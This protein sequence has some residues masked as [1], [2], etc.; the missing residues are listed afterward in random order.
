MLPGNVVGENVLRDF[1]LIAVFEVDCREI[2]IEPGI[3][4]VSLLRAI[5]ARDR[6][7]GDYRASSVTRRGGLADPSAFIVPDRSDSR[8]RAGAQETSVCAVIQDLSACSSRILSY[9]SHM[10]LFVAGK[11]GP[12]VASFFRLVGSNRRH[13]AALDS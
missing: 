6:R 1:K 8:N 12:S 11:L 5:I 9:I 7:G 2:P 10:P 4:L 3:R 13:M